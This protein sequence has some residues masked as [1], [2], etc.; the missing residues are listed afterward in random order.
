MNQ[1]TVDDML[2]NTVNHHHHQQQLI[3]GVTNA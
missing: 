1:L 3:K 2:L